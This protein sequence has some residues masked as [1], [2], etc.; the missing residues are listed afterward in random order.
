MPPRPR[1][2]LSAWLCAL[3]ILLP[4]SA[5]ALWVA[6][7][8][9]VATLP[10][11]QVSST[12]VSDGGGGAFVVWAGPST[13]RSA[14]GVYVQHV[15]HDGALDP[16]WPVAGVLVANHAFAQTSPAAV[17]DGVGGVIVAWQDERAPGPANMYAIRL[18][19]NGSTAPGWTP[20]STP[21]GRLL[22]NGDGT[23]YGIIVAADGTGGA[24]FAWTLSGTSTGDPS[25]VQA[26][27]VNASGALLYGATGTLLT[28]SG[29]QSNP[30][31]ASDGAGGAIIAWTDKATT[32]K[33]RA[34]ALG[35]NGLKK[36][37][38]ASVV[39]VTNSAAYQDIPQLLADGSG[40]AFIAWEQVNTDGAL[41]LW[42][43]RL[44]GSNGTSTWGA[45][46]KPITVVV[47]DQS[48]VKLIADGAGGLYAAWSDARSDL[49]R[50]VYATRLN[51]AGDYVQGWANGGDPIAS[52]QQVG[53]FGP[54]MTVDD[55]GGVVIA[56]YDNLGD[57]YAKRMTS[58]GGLAT[59]WSA[60]GNAVCVTED[61]QKDPSIVTDARGGGLV[62]FADQG[63]N[64]GDNVLIS[65]INSLG[66]NPPPNEW[67]PAGG[68]VAGGTF[69]GQLGAPRA[70][71]DGVGGEFVVWEQMTSAGTTDLYL[72]RIDASG[73][74]N[75]SWPEGGLRICGASGDQ[76]N[77]QIIS[78][79]GSTA[80]VVWEDKRSGNWDVYGQYIPTSGGPSWPA[81]GLALGSGAGDQLEPRP[82]LDGSFNAT[83]AW[84][85]YRAG[86]S[87]GDIYA[88]RASFTGTI[89]WT[90]NGVRLT[91]A[92]GTQ[93]LPDLL[94]DGSSGAIVT[95][96]GT[97]GGISAQHLNSTGG[98]L[99]GA[100]GATVH[101]SGGHHHSIADGASG[102]LV[103][104]EYTA[105]GNAANIYAQRLNASGQIATG[106]PAAA[107][108][109]AQT[110]YDQWY[111]RLTTDG[112]SGAIVVWRDRR[113][114]GSTIGDDLYGQRVLSSGA[115]ATGWPAAGVAICTAAGDQNE[116]S[117]VPDGSGGALIAWQDLRNQPACVGYGS[118]PNY[119]YSGCNVDV[120]AERLFST[121]VLD[122]NI[123]AGGLAL[124]TNSQLG[125]EL[126][127]LVM[128]SS[129][130]GVVAWHDNSL[131][132]YCP[133]CYG[134]IRDQRFTVDVTPPAAVTNLSASMDVCGTISVRW[135]AP[136]DD[137]S[138]GTA[139]AY[140]LRW[141]NHPITAQNFS[142]AW[143][144]Y[145][146]APLSSGSPEQHDESEVPA[147]TH[148]Y[149]ALKT[150]DES[151]NWSALSNAAGFSV[152]CSGC[153]SQ[154]SPAAIEGIPTHVE[155]GSR[156]PNPATSPVNFSLGLPSGVNGASIGIAVFDVVGRRVR[157]IPTETL[158]PGR[159]LVRW[160]LQND[161]GGTVANGIYYVEL[162]VGDRRWVQHL[163]V[164]R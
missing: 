160:N 55:L 50:D 155:F 57:V 16:I 68:I 37:G 164:L 28:G 154:S 24:V 142:S 22:S 119:Y 125:Q 18:Y 12:S 90:P 42:A 118:P 159:Q 84:T 151:N 62:T 145:Q 91:N 13:G 82:Y 92:A 94:S 53:E 97:G 54:S 140:D 66:Q 93:W 124:V 49:F 30:A 33:V 75:A 5:H 17:S 6:G 65:R 88:Q 4:A 127:T 74:V 135:T 21:G 7:G 64:T 108:R 2:T 15:L 71:S 56:W 26:Q 126:P 156:G 32:P 34:L 81:D 144:L 133:V 146:P 152:P 14:S 41:D 3:L 29:V 138:V 11:D 148:F 45:G 1:S 107:R 106:W 153:G 102:V 85:D 73:F 98:I 59:G 36:P 149:F 103:A 38:W 39:G 134:V 158:A 10:G 69:P 136:G 139:A 113:N 130:V 27:G 137:G 161:A 52:A 110:N 83:V 61:F 70:A 105:P 116:A 63:S 99:W 100:A 96:E 48:T 40:G 114:S 20:A 8:N 9:G 143:P 129:G 43:Q 67:V 131:Q 19:A 101:A 23:R 111:P 141:Y 76:K 47:N 150:R 77:P 117:M 60:A 162:R 95:W 112:A 109:L 157:R 80:L 31:I 89:A 104:F 87:N 35:T 44:N 78:G 86:T 115:V 147:C 25:D 128:T 79:A 123:P 58:T 120:F 132:P 122:P 72:Q 121:G 163:I 46:G 51:G